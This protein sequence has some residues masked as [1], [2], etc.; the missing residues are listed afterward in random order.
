MR[1]TCAVISG[2][3]L[4]SLCISQP[5][6]AHRPGL[7]APCPALQILVLLAGCQQRGVTSCTALSWA[8]GLHDAIPGSVTVPTWQ[9][10]LSLPM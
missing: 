4:C 9:H 5:C 10:L 6:S 7:N 1:R 2:E 3:L 8:L